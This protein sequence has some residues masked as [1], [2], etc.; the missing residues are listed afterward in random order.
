V[1]PATG[2]T[3]RCPNAPH[4][5]QRSVNKSPA[6]SWR[7]SA[8]GSTSNPR[9]CCPRARSRARSAR[10]SINGTRCAAYRPPREMI[11]STC[12]PTSGNPPEPDDL[13]DPPDAYENSALRCV[14]L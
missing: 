9:G 4:R 2:V 10:P 11:S 3:Y 7:S 1:S 12:S 5:S 14:L 8:L 13:R 6:R